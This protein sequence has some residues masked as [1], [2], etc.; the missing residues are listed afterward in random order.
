MVLGKQDAAGV[1]EDGVGAG[2]RRHGSSGGW[3]Q[4][5]EEDEAIAVTRTRRLEEA[6]MAEDGR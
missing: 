3:R 6:S 2:D 5:E 1:E 4:H